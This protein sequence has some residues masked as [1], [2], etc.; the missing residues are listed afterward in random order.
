MHHGACGE[1]I[2]L[3]AVLNIGELEH[4]SSSCAILSI[5]SGNQTIQKIYGF[6]P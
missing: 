6:G 3:N 5:L 1:G 2:S 4:I